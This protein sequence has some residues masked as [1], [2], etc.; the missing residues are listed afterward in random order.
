MKRLLTYLF[1]VLGLTILFQTKLYAPVIILAS[2]YCVVKKASWIGHVVTKM[3]ENSICDDI[4]VNPNKHHNFYSFLT[5]H[6]KGTGVFHVP[7]ILIGPYLASV[8][9]THLTLPTIC[10]V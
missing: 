8:S 10:S 5:G 4:I 6:D 7:E 2:D 9:Y 1:L 3:K